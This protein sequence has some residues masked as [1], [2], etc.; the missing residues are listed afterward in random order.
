M[1]ENCHIVVVGI[2]ASLCT[3]KL[4][5]QG[6]VQVLTEVLRMH[7]DEHQLC[8]LTFEALSEAVF[9]PSTVLSLSE[10]GTMQLLLDAFS[11]H[12][13][14]DFQVS[15]PSINFLPPPEGMYHCHCP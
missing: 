9:V 6:L 1:G 4:D 14:E 8:A 11:W 10:E 5:L 3:V 12:Q 2:V 13:E 15:L 7:Q